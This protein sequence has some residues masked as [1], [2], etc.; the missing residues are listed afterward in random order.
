[1][2]SD[3]LAPE[4]RRTLAPVD[5][6][7]YQTPVREV[8]RRRALQGLITGAAIVG[9]D[10]ATRSWAAEAGPGLEDVPPLDGS[11]TLDP[12]S[13]QEAADDYGHI[14]H[15]Q[16]LAVLRPG[17]AA[18][19][20]TVIGFARR[21]RLKVAMRGQG[22]ACFGQAQV[23]AGLVIDSRTLNR[24][25][26]IRADRAV[27]DPGITWG[28]LLQATAPHGLTPP[29]L[30]DFMGLSVGGTL[31]GG[32]IG[33]ATQHHG[34][35]LDTALELTVATGRGDL[36]RC[37][38]T[39]NRDLFDAV[40]GG[41]GQ[42]GVIVRATVA[43]V[44]A[45]TNA[46]VYNLFYDDIDR[47]LADQLTLLADGRFSYL[48][49]Q[50]QASTSGWRYMIEAVSYLDQ[51]DD[52]ALLAGLSDDRAAATI[53]PNTYLGWAFR[54]EPAVVFL[55]AIGDWFRPHPLLDLLVPVSKAAGVVGGALAT[56][57]PPDIG[58]GPI[59]LYPVDTRR[60][61]RP[62]FRAPAEPSAFL[63]SLLRTTADGDPTL[64][65]RQLASNRT[66]HDANRDAGGTW[67]PIGAI[68]DYGPTDWRRH[69]GS[70][71]PVV[72]KAKRTFD[73]DNVLTPG[74][75]MFV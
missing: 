58:I 74:Q 2:E 68:A 59:L 4:G 45:P 28:E 34:A 54:L 49:G 40:L 50:V 70:L 42:Y 60:F 23:Q 3:R 14:V 69:Y 52:A 18:D 66:I 73:P 36:V 56:L 64:L 44:P 37:S 22:H 67:Y 25:H 13:R 24:V 48:E 38:A 16:P 11:L 26:D 47:Y 20:A 8:T 12:G 33:G 10:P 39:C 7:G 71:W 61:T 35:Q 31:S 43:L 53:T 6:V 9:F 62:L 46:R 63:F 29:V 21:H 15:R 51:P 72:V 17:S 57:T 30:T 75:R 27:V 55:K 5:S 19:V 32:G 1:V 41:F 65:S